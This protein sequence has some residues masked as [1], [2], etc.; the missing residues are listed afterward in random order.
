MSHGAGVIVINGHF[1]NQTFLEEAFSNNV[2]T[3]WPGSTN[4]T[5]NHGVVNPSGSGLATSGAN[6]GYL[7]GPGFIEQTLS[8]TILTGDKIIVTFDAYRN[9][10][11][12][13]N[14]TVNFAGLGAQTVN[15][16]TGAN[17][18][19]NNVI[20]FTATSDLTSGI[21]RFDH[22]GSGTQSRIDTVSVNVVPEPSFIALLGIGGLAMIL[23]RR[24]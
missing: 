18:V 1:D 16:G 4:T 22:S 7:N 3:G 10:G 6:V 24:K 17:N 23:R 2:I 19:T 21:L 14:L 9:N 11:V 5:F 12:V 20:T 13:N 15:L 8:A